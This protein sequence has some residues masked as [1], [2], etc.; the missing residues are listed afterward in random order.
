VQS[1]GVLRLVKND[2]VER[3]EL[4]PPGR[5]LDR[6]AGVRVARRR[7]GGTVATTQ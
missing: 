4:A 1:S 7:S 2:A 3:T 5:Q 6:A